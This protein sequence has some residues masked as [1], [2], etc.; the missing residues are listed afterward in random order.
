M[1]RYKGGEII[2]LLNE[3]LLEAIQTANIALADTQRGR[4][5]HL[6]TCCPDVTVSD[7][8]VNDLHPAVFD[9]GQSTLT[10]AN[11]REWPGVEKICGKVIGVSWQEI[12]MCPTPQ[13]QLARRVLSLTIQT[14]NPT[15]QIRQIPLTRGSLL[16]FDIQ[17][18]KTTPS[19]AHDALEIFNGLELRETI[20]QM[21]ASVKYCEDADERVELISEYLLDLGETLGHLLCGK[22]TVS[23]RGIVFECDGD[24]VDLDDYQ[25]QATDSRFIEFENFRTDGVDFVQIGNDWRVAVRLFDDD[26][27]FFA[28]PDIN[29]T[30]ELIFS[31]V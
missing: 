1:D 2:E 7:F 26:Q 18:P 29:N 16:Q 19:E 9:D 25:L 17:I 23:G 15:D 21:E 14:S 31:E 28:V 12:P 20:N 22:Y 4:R 27:F 3:E 11:N 13:G 10:I 24:G 5:N 30:N 8:A 6:D